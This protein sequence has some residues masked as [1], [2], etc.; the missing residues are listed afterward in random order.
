MEEQSTGDRAQTKKRLIDKLRIAVGGLVVAA[1]SL[2]ASPAAEASTE[3]PQKPSLEERVS[4]LQKQIGVAL[5]EQG[6]A[7]AMLTAF[8]NWGNHWDNW[9]NW[10]N[11]ANWHNHH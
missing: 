7:S 8:N 4:Q 2:S 5:P 11:W 3:S 9:H 6:E 10:H 1:A